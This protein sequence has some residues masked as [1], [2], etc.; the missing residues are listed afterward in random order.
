MFAIIVNSQVLASYIS[1]LQ[2]L[3]FLYKESIK[4]FFA[5]NCNICHP[6][7]DNS[8]T[9]IYCTLYDITKLIHFSMATVQ[10]LSSSASQNGCHYHGYCIAM[11]KAKHTLYESPELLTSVHCGPLHQCRPPN[12]CDSGNCMRTLL[13]GSTAPLR[14]L[15][16]PSLQPGA[17]RVKCCVM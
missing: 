13:Q 10:W 5:L 11:E 9:S 1:R 3:Q 4:F 6:S 2:L 16:L 7:Q 12:T 17:Q 15:S 8:P 14:P